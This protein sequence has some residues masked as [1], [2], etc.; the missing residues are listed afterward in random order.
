MSPKL[1]AF[2]LMPF[3][4]RSDI[5]YREVIKPTC[6]AAGL[7][8]ERIDEQI[9]QGSILER[10]YD[11]IDAADLVIADLTAK[12]PNVFYE[13][14]Y[15]HAQKK[16]ALLLTENADDIPFD[17]KHYQH[18]VYNVDWPGGVAALQSDLL[19]RLRWVGEHLDE[20]ALA[21]PS[22]PRPKLVEPLP[23]VTRNEV[24]VSYCHR[25]AKWLRRLQVH[26]VPLERDGNIKHWD[27]TMIDPGDE[28]RI[29][30]RDA[31][32]RAKVAILLVSADFIASQ[33]VHTNELPPLLAAAKS[34]GAI[35]LPVIIS[36]CRFEQIAN[37]A[38]FQA[39]NPP[40]KP[41]IGMSKT[42]QEQLFVN[43]TN[44]VEAAISSGTA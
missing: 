44:Q 18:I 8:C 29:K 34:E 2:V 1:F 35:I 20:P 7:R 12:N 28:W 5:F 25:D 26:M 9:F 4:P 14:G 19:K 38:Q 11:Q 31:L 36:P 16:P 13:V 27:D 6:E 22:Q 43:V 3:S 30:I 21:Q 40:S 17:L 10:I 32:A 33:F 42:Q 23:S 41:L 37:L 15:A 39:V 24:F